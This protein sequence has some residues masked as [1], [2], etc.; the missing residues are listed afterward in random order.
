MA[1]RDTPHR[2]RLEASAT[3]G[4]GQSTPT[5]FGSRTRHMMSQYDP[6]RLRLVGEDV[7]SGGR[8]GIW[9]QAVV[10][11]TTN[12][13]WRTAKEDT[14]HYVTPLPERLCLF[15]CVLGVFSAILSCQITIGTGTR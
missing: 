4:H 9:Q 8:H 7:R 3:P 13:P 15:F 11:L 2:G 12:S 10:I 6:K 14:P 1:P 5:I